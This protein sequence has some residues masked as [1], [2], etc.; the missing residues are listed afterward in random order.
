M[1]LIHPFHGLRYSPDKAGDLSLVMTQP[2]DKISPEMQRDYYRRS[3]FNV[4][5]ITKNFEK[6]EDPDTTYPDAA[7]TFER[8]I[9]EGMLLPDPKPAIY[10]YFRE[11]EVEGEKRSQQ[12]FISLLDLAH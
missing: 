7:A 6:N 11:Y 3:P 1:A 5:R 8:W 10:A 12:G 4:V 2:Y 9:A